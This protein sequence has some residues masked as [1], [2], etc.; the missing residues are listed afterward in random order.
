[1][2]DLFL[3][4]IGSG[5]GGV[6]RFYLNLIFQKYSSGFPLG[7]LTAN[8]LGTFCIGLCSVLILEKN[9]LPDYTKELILLGFLGGL[10]TFSS[11]GY[12]SFTLYKNHLYFELSLYLF[13]NL[14]VG[15]ILLII[16]RGIGNL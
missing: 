3:I 10:T 7:T 12:D 8:L 13:G 14:F 1:M 5:L 11:F 6:L 4:F 16:G 9:Y 15:F 2:R